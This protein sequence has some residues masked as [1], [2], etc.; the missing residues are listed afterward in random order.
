MLC[1]KNPIRCS[2]F[3]KQ[4]QRNDLQKQQKRNKYLFLFSFVYIR[5]GV[6]FFFFFFFVFILNH[7]NPNQCQHNMLPKIK[8]NHNER[9]RMN[10]FGKYSI[11]FR[12]NTKT[13]L[14]SST[15]THI[16]EFR[17]TKY[18]FQQKNNLQNQKPPKSGLSK[19]CPKRT[20]REKIKCQICCQKQT[21]A[22]KIKSSK[23]IC[24]H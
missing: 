24:N 15:H 7:V 11:I 22:K 4:R 9:S 14:T 16:K 23:K 8:P 10:T 6:I 1:E 18:L 17:V 5:F 12:A 20:R 2:S 19:Y 3:Y 13:W 21:T